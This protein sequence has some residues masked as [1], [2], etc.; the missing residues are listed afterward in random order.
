MPPFTIS[1]NG[2]EE[3]VVTA[4]SEEVARC[5]APRKVV[6]NVPALVPGAKCVHAAHSSHLQE[7][8]YGTNLSSKSLC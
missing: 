5:A 7:D 4:T 3:E 6:S 8:G 1:D 2:H